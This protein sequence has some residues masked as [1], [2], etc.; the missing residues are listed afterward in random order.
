MRIKG[1]CLYNK[2]RTVL[3]HNQCPD[4]F[5]IIVI[6]QP[7]VSIQTREMCHHF[8]YFFIFFFI[9]IFFWPSY[10]TPF[11]TM[12]SCVSVLFKRCLL[13]TQRGLDSL[14]SAQRHLGIAILFYWGHYVLS[15]LNNFLLPSATSP[16]PPPYH[17]L[18]ME[19]L[20]PATRYELDPFPL[21]LS[22]S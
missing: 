17:K 13:A 4:I 22:S 5:T 10:M 21:E 20:V 2:I 3:S 12:C 8:I 16:L 11:Y 15:S 7:N 9:I 19:S 14:C 6:M 1:R 18:F